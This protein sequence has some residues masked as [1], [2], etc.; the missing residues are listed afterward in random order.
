MLWK[1]G[2]PAVTEVEGE[3]DV[4]VR[5]CFDHILR[6]AGDR[7]QWF[8]DADVLSRF[9][10]GDGRLVVQ[11]VGSGNGNDFGIRIGD[12]VEIG[13]RLASEP[14]GHRLGPLGVQVVHYCQLRT[15]IVCIGIGVLFADQPDT[16]NRCFRLFLAHARVCPLVS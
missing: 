11:M 5:R 16:D 8:L 9:E 1:P 14:V 7:G 4:V 2:V 15:P 12:V 6:F 10:H 13:C 3:L